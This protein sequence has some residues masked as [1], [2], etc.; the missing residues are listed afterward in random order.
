MASF[1]GPGRLE[2]RAL[3]R[4]AGWAAL[5]ADRRSAGASPPCARLFALPPRISKPADSRRPQKL[6]HGKNANRLYRP[7]EPRILLPW[8]TG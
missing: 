2:T 6:T 5:V 7:L 3:R 1:T 8:K 4:R